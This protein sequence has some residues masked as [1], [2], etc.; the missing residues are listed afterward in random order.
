VR[1]G[2]DGQLS[3]GQ[4]LWYVRPS[5]LGIPARGPCAA[6]AAAAAARGGVCAA[7]SACATAPPPQNQRY[8]TEQ[9]HI[10]L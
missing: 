6:V 3:L 4:N 2:G 5:C 8:V 1:T 10:L 9:K 7:R